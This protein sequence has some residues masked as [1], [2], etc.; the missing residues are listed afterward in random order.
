MNRKKPFRIK[1]NDFSRILITET[2]PYETPII[3][4]NDGLRR[5]V[6]ATFTAESVRG[7][8]TNTLVKKPDGDSTVPFLYKIRKDSLAFRRLALVHPAS[9]WKMM[10]FY[11]KYDQLLIHYCKQSPVS[12]R[13]PHKVASTYYA[14]NSWENIYQYKKGNVSTVSIDKLAKHSPSYFSYFGFDRLYKFFESADYLTL[15]KEF[16][17]MWFLDVSKCFDSIYTHTLSWAVKDKHFTKKYKDIR[18]TFAQSFDFLMTSSNHSETNGIVIGPEVSRIFAEIIFQAIDRRTIIRLEKAH[19]LTIEVDYCLRRYVDD[20]FIFSRNESDAQ[21]IYDC[22]SDNLLEFNLHANTL[23]SSLRLRRP[24]VTKKSTIVNGASRISN[25]FFSKFLDDVGGQKLAPKD[26]RHRWR[27]SLSFID[28][29]KSLCGQH[30]VGYDEVSSY[31]IAVFSERIKKL[32]NVTAEEETNPSKTQYRDALVVL[33]EVMYFLYSVAPSVSAS[34]KVCTSIT[35]AI[36][37]SEKYLKDYRTTIC[38][39]IYELTE[40]LVAKP[41]KKNAPPVENLVC[42]ETVNLVLALRDVGDEYLLTEQTIEALFMPGDSANY[43]QVITC[44]YYM[45]GHG[46]YDRLR[47]KIIS[48]VLSRLADLSNIA[49]DSEQVHLLLDLLSCPYVD[50]GHKRKWLSD[51]YNSLN[52]SPARPAEINSFLADAA[53]WPW[54]VNWAELDLL[55]SL[56]KKE[57]K[58]A[59]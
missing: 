19:G 41:R 7:L 58:R 34:Y 46:K 48:W 28:S 6:E 3:F 44:L 36:R 21:T 30:G 45:Q 54:F 9:Q 24:F 33:L 29:I 57:L 18:S 23:K 39:R 12:I 10:L 32:V 31:L 53:S 42:L 14:K 40:N 27:L 37:F 11:Q 59:Y 17:L 15:E 26:I 22:Y 38:Q 43:F 8:L 52:Q 50:E 5:H 56:E 1:K 20:I 13:A 49:S 51:L 25:D 35:V 47:T 2:I 16:N 55:N 4:S